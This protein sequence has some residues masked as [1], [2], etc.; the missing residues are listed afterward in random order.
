MEQQRMVKVSVEVGSDNARFRVG[1]QAPSVRHALRM[2]KGR[3]PE[4]EVRGPLSIEAEGSPTK[5]PSDPTMVVG[6]E[7]IYQDAA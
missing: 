6:H 7:R 3:Y 2:L 1:V 5:E 4:G